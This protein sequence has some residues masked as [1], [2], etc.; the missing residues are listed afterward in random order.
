MKAQPFQRIAISFAV[1][2]LLISNQCIEAKLLLCIYFMFSFGLWYTLMNFY[3]ILYYTFVTSYFGY[4]HIAHI[5]FSCCFDNALVLYLMVPTGQN[6]HNHSCWDRISSKTWASHKRD[7]ASLF[8]WQVCILFCS[9][10]H[11][12]WKTCKTGV[13]PVEL[14]H[15]TWAKV[16]QSICHLSHQAN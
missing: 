1:N 15:G 7:F 4:L 8:A 9:H 11:E 12:T 3:Y 10:S 14:L 13:S 2:V 5:L 16:V 6:R